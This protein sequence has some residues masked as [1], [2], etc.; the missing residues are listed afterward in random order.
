MDGPTATPSNVCPETC[1]SSAAW[2]C[3][4]GKIAEMRTGEGKTLVATLPGYLNALSRQGRP[5]RHGQRLPRPPRRRVDGPHLPVP[6]PDGRR[7]QHDR[8]TS[9][10]QDAYRCDI[11]Y[12][13]NNE[14]G[15]DYLRDNMKFRAQTTSSAS[16]TTRSSTRSTRSSSTRRARRSS[17]RGPAERRPTSTDRQPGH[18]RLIRDEDYAVDEKAHSVTLTDEGVEKVEKLL[19][20]ENLYDPA[21][22]RRCT[23]STRRCARTRSTSATSTTW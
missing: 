19:G 16:S 12:G 21:T 1:S 4:T 7:R 11:T 18:P 9:E 5:R 15:F 20:V 10:R 22:S 23:T 3:T 17:S 14:F 6:R 13:Q 8:R 2:S